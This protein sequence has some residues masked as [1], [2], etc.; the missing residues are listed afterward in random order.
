MAKYKQ[1]FDLKL[2]AEEQSLL[3]KG[4]KKS[5][6]EPPKKPYNFYQRWR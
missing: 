1:N 3:S 6:A 4:E 5:S 2:T